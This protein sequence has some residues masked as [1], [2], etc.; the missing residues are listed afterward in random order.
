ME[1]KYRAVAVYGTVGMELVASVLLGL[2]GGR[3]LDQRYGT[4]YWALAGFL[5][6]VVLGFR[7]ILRAA[8]DLARDAEREERERR[9]P[10]S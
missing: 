10:P 4:H 6:G 2:F 5:L 9:G 1:P 7:A 8:S 3:W